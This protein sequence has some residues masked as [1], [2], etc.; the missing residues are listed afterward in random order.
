MGPASVIV[1]SAVTPGDR[2]TSVDLAGDAIILANGELVADSR[3]DSAD[4]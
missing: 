1:A 2:I 3:A 4:E